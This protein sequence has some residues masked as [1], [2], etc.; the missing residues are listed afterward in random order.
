MSRHDL[1]PLASVRVF[2]AAARHLSFTRAADELGMTQAA[3][4]YQIKMLE[5]RVGAPLFIRRPRAVELTAIG[6]TLAVAASKA[7]DQVGSAFEAVRERASGV[8]SINVIPTFAVQKLSPI[9]GR[10]QIAH[11]DLATRITAT[12]VL[13][14]FASEEVDVAIRS[15]KG[16]WPGLRSHE[17]F[18]ASFTPMLGPALLERYGP[19]REPRDLLKLPL[20]DA[21]DPWWDAWFTAAGVDAEELK[22]RPKSSMGDQFLEARMALGG[23]GVAIL[24]PDFY[25]SELES[26]TLIQPFPLVEEMGQSY[27]LCY[28]ERRRNVPKIKA[29]RDWLLAE[30]ADDM[31]PDASPHS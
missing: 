23:M 25:R 13:T 11:P 22:E 6:D 7:L 26:G 27:W 28:S 1:P 29:F 18:K 5:D 31:K 9:L 19:Q 14:D 2:E 10:F 3:V 15:G 12:R 16:K 20:I 17:L 24:T 30:M 21:R 8:L 4:S